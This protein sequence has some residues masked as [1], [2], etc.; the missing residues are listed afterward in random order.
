MVPQRGNHRSVVARP[1]TPTSCKSWIDAVEV[2]TSN[3]HTPDGSYPGLAELTARIGNLAPFLS[4][5]R[6][7]PSDDLAI[8]TS[9]MT[10]YGWKLTMRGFGGSRAP[11]ISCRPSTR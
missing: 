3:F 4:V 9:A 8:G 5:A 7:T 1:P 11:K 6:T 2:A 10:G